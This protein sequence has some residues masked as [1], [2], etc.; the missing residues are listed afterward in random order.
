MYVDLVAKQKELN[1]PLKSAKIA[2]TG[3]AAC[4]PK[5]FMDIKSTFGLEKVKVSTTEYYFKWNFFFLF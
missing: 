4:S 3:G 5:L 1:L 2:V